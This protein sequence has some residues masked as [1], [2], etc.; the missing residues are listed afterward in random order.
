MWFTGLHEECVFRSCLVGRNSAGCRLNR[1]L[2]QPGRL[3]R[4][5][6]RRT[7]D[8]VVCRP[9]HSGR[10]GHRPGGNVVRQVA[11]DGGTT[12]SGDRC[13]GGAASGG[14]CSDRIFVVVRVWRVFRR[15]RAAANR[16][17]GK[18]LCGGHRRW[19]GRWR[20][21]PFGGRVF[22]RS[23]GRWKKRQL[24]GYGWRRRAGFPSKTNGCRNTGAT[25]ST[26]G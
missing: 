24:R 10:A 15:S 2:T 6:H 1:A 23:G 5:S 20:A 3:D 26:R 4:R 11:I 7:V 8:D 25:P 12:H 21:R 9:L 14:G 13:C 18:D 17:S 22:V 19:V 16:T